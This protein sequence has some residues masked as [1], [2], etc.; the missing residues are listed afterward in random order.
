MF[1]GKSTISRRAKE[2]ERFAEDYVPYKCYRSST[3]HR[4][5]KFKYENV[6]RHVLSALSLTE[7]A[8]TEAMEIAFTIDYAHVCST[9]DRGHV[10]AGVKIIEYNK[11]R[12]G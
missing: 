3:N 10:L 6:L 9:I 7:K 11:T 12:D 1:P 5:I 4:N 8:K 2:L